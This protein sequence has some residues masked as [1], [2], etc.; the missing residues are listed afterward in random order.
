M[1]VLMIKDVA[2]V[3]KRGDVRN[4]KDGFAR[5][6]LLPQGFAR[7]ADA[8]ALADAASRKLHSA[9]TQKAKEAELSEY[10]MRLK[11]TALVF[12]KKANEKGHLFASVM[13]GDIVRELHRLGFKFITGKMIEGAPFKTTGPHTLTVAEVPISVSVEAA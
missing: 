10:R 1:K 6:F 9:S 13:A 2:R 4:V 7:I 12:R 11:S 5:N 8:Q 3:G